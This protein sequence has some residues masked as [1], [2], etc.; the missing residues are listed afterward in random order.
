MCIRF[1]SLRLGLAKA[2]SLRESWQGT[3]ISSGGSSDLYC[4]E[5]RHG[6]RAKGSLEAAALGLL[7]YARGWQRG[8]KASRG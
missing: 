3:A 6:S 8:L 2:N 7:E 1:D 4:G 5:S